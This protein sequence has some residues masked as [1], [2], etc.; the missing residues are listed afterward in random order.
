MEDLTGKSTGSNLTAA[1][2]NQLPQEVQN[3]ITDL[4][5]SL[6]SGDL[7]Q[8]GKAMAA[9]LAAGQYYTC[10][11][12]SNAFVLTKIGNKQAPASYHD[13]MT[14]RFRPNH[15]STG[16]ATIN[17]NSIGVVDLKREDAS[18]IAAGDLDTTRDCTARYDDATGDFFV[19]NSSLLTGLAS[20]TTGDVTLTMKVAADSGWVL[21]DDGNI[22]N[23]ASGATTRANADCEALFTLLWNN[24]SNPTAN[25]Y[26][27][28]SGGLG[29]SAAAD[30][31]SNKTLDLPISLGRA[32]ACSGT[33]SGLSARVLGEEMGDEDALSQH[34]HLMFDRYSNPSGADG[35]TSGTYAADQGHSGTSDER[36]WIQKSDN[37][38]A[39]PPTV[40]KNQLVGLTSDGA[41]QPSVFLNVMIKL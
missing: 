10:T 4:G 14:I 23:G 39:D 35:V 37:S 31:A 1:E 34:Q 11:G 32:L 36:Y 28:V 8:L 2:W 5:L 16:A 3:I 22:G 24:V 19:M 15:T 29:G 21:F 30:W 41:M 7:D 38:G 27:A 6:S 17:V 9:F 25:A 40:G 18:A 20:W 12:S 13:G 26:C 33:G